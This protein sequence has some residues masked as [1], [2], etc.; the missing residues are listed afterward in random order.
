MAAPVPGETFAD[1]FSA[2]W[3]ALVDA[4]ALR[5]PHY[6]SAK[7][8]PLDGGVVCQYDP[9]H[10]VSKRPSSVSGGPIRVVREFNPDAFHFGRVDPRREFVCVLGGGAEEPASV[11]DDW[12]AESVVWHPRLAPDVPP[13]AH[14]LAV[15]VNPLWEGHCLFVP[16]LARRLPQVLSRG[17]LGAALGLAASVEAPDFRLGFNSLGAWASVNHLHFHAGFMGATIP[18]RRFPCESAARRELASAILPHPAGTAPPGGIDLRLSLARTTD[19]PLPLLVFAAEDAG[20]SSEEAAAPPPWQ[21]RALSAA[22]GAVIEAAQRANVA[23]NV[24]CA[25]RG[26]RVYVIPRQLQPERGGP[27]EGAMAVALAEC[28]GLAITYSDAAYEAMDALEFARLL[29][30]AALP[31]ADLAQLEEV[32]VAAVLAAAAGTA[33]Q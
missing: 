20:G 27:A 21:R 31:A 15:N 17:A 19:W 29:A 23:H 2:A 33:A 18:G 4:G 10:L 5:N 9:A 14:A 3:A 26:R 32:A 13:G 16:A 7:R 22:V 12:E 6:R 28:C 25:D 1:S 11:V 30:A 8:R 24:L